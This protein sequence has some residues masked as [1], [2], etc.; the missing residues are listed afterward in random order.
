MWPMAVV[1]IDIL[2]EHHLELTSAEDQHPV[3]T[4]PADRPDEPLGEG[5]G[6][7]SSDGCADDPDPRNSIHVSPF[8]R[9]EGSMPWRRRMAQTLDGA[10]RIPIVASSPWIRRY[11]QVE[12]SL[13]N[14][15][16][17][18]TVPAGTLGRPER[19]G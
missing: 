16:T 17:I 13:A 15:R 9:G 1:V 7:R 10:S 6:P 19:W 2:G 5:V 3:E 12:F 18:S 4:L 11:P 14:R 8:R